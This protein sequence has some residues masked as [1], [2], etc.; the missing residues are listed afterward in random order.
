MKNDN[1]TINKS[2]INF[3]LFNFLPKDLANKKLFNTQTLIKIL[4]FLMLSR[5]LSNK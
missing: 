2:F 1:I 3:R 4:I 5:I